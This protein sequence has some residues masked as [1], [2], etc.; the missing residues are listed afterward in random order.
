MRLGVHSAN[1]SSVDMPADSRCWTLAEE[2]FKLNGKVPL[3]SDSGHELALVAQSQLFSDD[4]WQ[5]RS[6]RHS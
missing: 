4:P 1:L 5:N 6:K 2:V 3:S